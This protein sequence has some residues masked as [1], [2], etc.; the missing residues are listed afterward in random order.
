MEEISFGQYALPVILMVGLAFFYKI[1]DKADGT[2]YI[3]NRLKPLIAISLG[4]LLGIVAMFYNGIQPIFKNV[5]DYVLYG[6][7]AGA[8]AVGLWEGFSAVKSGGNGAVK[9][10]K[11]IPIAFLLPAMIV[12]SLSG[13]VNL[14]TQW[15]S[16][17]EDERVR[18]V[19]DQTQTGLDALLDMGVAYVAAH[20]EK[21]AEWQTRVLPLFKAVNAMIG[22][23]I[24][25]A[26]AN[27]GKVTVAGVL[28]AIQPK[29][30]K[31]ETIAI[32]WGF[33]K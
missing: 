22:E 25:F 1:F 4:M 28:A 21:K 10:A 18:I 11:M 20:P 23:N 31:I 7:M 6:F 33:K 8:G 29:I 16:A 32:E 17:T 3:P 12:G 13:C 2:S 19:L 24:R 15:N 30:T 14:Q 9:A 5:V 27:A 26:K